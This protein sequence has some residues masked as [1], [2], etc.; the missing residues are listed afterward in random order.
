MHKLEFS[1]LAIAQIHPGDSQISS[2]L[3]KLASVSSNYLPPDN[4]LYDVDDI[5]M[6]ELRKIFQ[7][8]K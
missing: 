7:E 3:R 8:T 4:H 1:L 5:S 6:K 2:L